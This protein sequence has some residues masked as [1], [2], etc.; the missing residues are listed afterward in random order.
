MHIDRKEENVRPIFW[1][2]R[3]KSYIQRTAT[4]DDFPNGRFG[5]RA[6]PAF[7]DFNYV[8]MCGE[9]LEKKRNED[10]K[11][12]GEN[13]NST[14]DVAAVFENF[15]LGKVKR[16]PWCDT[17]P[18][19]ETN[20]VSHQLKKIIRHGCF[21]INSQPRVNAALSSDPYVGWGPAD[22]FVYQKAY[23]EFFCSP[24]VLDKILDHFVESRPAGMQSILSYTAVNREG[25]I[26][27]NMATDSVN[28]VTWGVFPNREVVQPTVAD[29]LSFL[30]WKDEAF[31]LWK[32]WEV[33]YAPD[34]TS[35]EIIEDIIGNYYLVTM[36]DNNF[37]SGD[38]F[39]QI[40]EAVC[41]ASI[42]KCTSKSK[43]K[44]G[45]SNG[46][47]VVDGPI[48]NGKMSQAAA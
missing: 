1:A 23:V 47:N 36:V 22:G 41:T 42:A 27:T 5:N 14:E 44:N 24:E 12:W 48:A 21:T 26:R 32:E 2:N 18:S 6:S 11:M 37:V 16:L 19:P 38:L 4:W 30:A 28:A 13:L 17:C 31:E 40:V 7:G 3:Q 8:S 35:R 45:Y 9:S 29:A 10:R 39:G 43:L 33:L 25:N 20:F 46:V 34:S 15:L